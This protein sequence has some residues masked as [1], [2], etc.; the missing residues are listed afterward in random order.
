MTIKIISSNSN[1]RL[2]K[3]NGKLVVYTYSL[4]LSKLHTHK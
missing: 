1:R 3:L 2:R 4:Q